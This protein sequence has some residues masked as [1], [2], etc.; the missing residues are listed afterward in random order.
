MK[1][2]N[3]KLPKYPTFTR[4]GYDKQ[5]LFLNF[6]RVLPQMNQRQTHHVTGKES[7]NLGSCAGSNIRRSACV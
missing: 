3:I 6:E 7:F 5:T 1:N 4:I 2:K